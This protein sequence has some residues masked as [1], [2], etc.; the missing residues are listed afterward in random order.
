MNIL[1]IVSSGY[2]TYQTYLE[3]YVTFQNFSAFTTKCDKV[4]R[5]KYHNFLLNIKSKE[6]NIKKDEVEI[7]RQ[8]ILFLKKNNLSDHLHLD[9]LK[10]HACK[11]NDSFKHFSI[12][13]YYL[14][15]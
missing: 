4:K 11:Y 14:E 10:S 2:K 8:V 9:S 3:K 15:H 5:F 13:S 12:P 6:I 7:N 1:Y